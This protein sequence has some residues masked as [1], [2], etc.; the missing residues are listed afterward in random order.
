ME[1]EE[2]I[3]NFRNFGYDKPTVIQFFPSEHELISYE[4]TNASVEQI[5]EKIKGLEKLFNCKN[6]KYVTSFH[7]LKMIKTLT[8]ANSTKTTWQ[9]FAEN[10]ITIVER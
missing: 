9:L 2:I 1:N 5:C 10:G 3:I 7:S 4:I 6:V 8:L